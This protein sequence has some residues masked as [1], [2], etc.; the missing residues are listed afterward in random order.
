GAAQLDAAAN[1]PGTFVYTPP[2]GTVVSA[3][4]GQMLSAM[5]TPTDTANYAPVAKT[6]TIDVVSAVSSVTVTADRPS[7]QVPGTTVTFTAAASGGTAPYQYKWWLSD[8]TT[9]TVVQAWSATATFVWTPTSANNGYVVAV[10]V[11]S[12]GNAVDAA[13]KS[14]GLPYPIRPAVS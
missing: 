4:L 1:V 7:P 6:V 5:F 2:S 10:W 9:W 14:V 12:A 8:G 11:R 13:E 3:G